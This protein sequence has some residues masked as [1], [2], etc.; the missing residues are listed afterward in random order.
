MR[1]GWLTLVE[2][3][4][5]PELRVAVAVLVERVE[6][7]AVVV[8]DV[9]I[10]LEGELFVVRVVVAVV[11]RVELPVLRV[12]VAVPVDLLEVGAVV[13]RVAVPVALEG[14]PVV[15]RV[16]PCERALTVF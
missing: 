6:P 2:R 12:A 13:V 8:R 16:T 14:A 3:V 9:P 15:V 4:E 7:E 11:V 10:D 5:L 1:A